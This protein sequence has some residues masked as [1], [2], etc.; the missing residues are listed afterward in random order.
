VSSSAD[1]AQIYRADEVETQYVEAEGVRYAY[2]R[3]GPENPADA[4]PIV[5][6]HRF[7]GTLDD[8]DPA[9]VDALAET[10]DVVLF[11]DAGIGSSTG[12]FA[13]TIEAKARN[14]VSFIEALGLRKVDLLGFSMGGFSCQE[15]ALTRPDLVRNLVLVGTAGGGNPEMDPPTDIVFPTALK[16]E[17]AH[18]DVRYLF[19]A[20]GRDEET[21]AYMDRV[22]VR[23]DREPIVPPEGI[24][25]LQNAA[26]TFI[27]GETKHFDRLREI[28]HPALIVS[29]D[30]DNFFPVKNQWL[31]FREL[32]NAQLAVY[33]Q[34]GHGP[35][36]QHPKTVAAQIERFLTHA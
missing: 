33:P 9:F 36:Q 2:R 20:E 34:A 3:L 32:P 23:K 4:T 14:A 26:V 7:R 8:W 24:K 17:Y 11:S 13:D 5:F 10:R 28:Q 31:L 15:I 30:Q 19:F 1:S 27:T 12:E 25:A 16:P 22:A 18:E 6:L 21:H 29:G 35:H